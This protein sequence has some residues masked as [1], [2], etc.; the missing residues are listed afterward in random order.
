MKRIGVLLSGCGVKD[1]SEIHEAVLT[2]LYLD[3]RGVERTCIAPQ[4]AQARVVDHLTGQPMPGE[5]DV[6]VESSRLARGEV[7]PLARVR[8]EELSGLILPGGLG[9]ALNLCDYA[10]QGRAMRVRPDVA[11]LLLALHAQGKPIGA[12]CIAPVLVAKVFGD[13]GIAIEVTVGDSTGVAADIAA[14]GAV[15]VMR[16]VDE[17]HVDRAHRIVSTPA[18]M[19]GGNVAQIAPGIERVVDSVVKLA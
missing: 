1:G 3:Q 16:R 8:P 15:H 14:F 18:Y 10:L 19:L 5:R 12:I 4:M 9:A 11:E 2:L 6:L 7:M 17:I 13:R